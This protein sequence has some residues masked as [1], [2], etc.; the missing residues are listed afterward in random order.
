MLLPWY[1]NGTLS[2]EDRGRIEALLAA[3]PDLRAELAWLETV[4]G[5]LKRS[6]E[7]GT[8]DGGLGELLGRI[9][10]P[11]E[12]NVV[13]IAPPARPRWHMPALAIAASLVLVQAVVIGVL[14]QQ[15]DET[16]RPLSGPVDPRGV[17]LQVRFQ[18]QATEAEMRGL[19]T[20]IGGELVAG[21]GA[22]GLYTVRV[23]TT[24]VESARAALAA[25]VDVVES[26]AVVPR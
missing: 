16:L 9:D 7:A 1:A 12:G 20:G 11:A 14:V 4:R 23:D 8:D 5:E 19:L 22:L 13:P 21:P 10:V 6:T 26:V 15:P 18:P 25:R 2:L 17:L 24:R 3:S